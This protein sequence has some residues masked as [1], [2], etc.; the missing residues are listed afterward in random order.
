[1]KYLT[2]NTNIKYLYLLIMGAS[3]SVDEAQLKALQNTV[4]SQAGKINALDALKSKVDNLSTA[5]ASGI[6]YTKLAEAINKEANYREN[7]AKEIA[8]NPNELGANLA[9]EIGKNNSIIE[10]LNSK[11]GASTTLQDKVADTLSSNDKYK[12]RIRGPKGVDGN[13]GDQAALKSNLF[14]KGN[15]MWCADG[16]FCQIPDKKKGGDLGGIRLSDKWSGYPDAQR[17]GKW[18]SEISNDTDGFKKLMIVGNK[19]GG[20][21][22]RVGI[23]DELQVHGNLLV[24]GQT[25]KFHDTNFGRRDDWIRILQN[26]DDL[27]SYN[28]GIAAKNL[29][30]RDKL[31]V[32]GRDILAEIDDIKN[33]YVPKNTHIRIRSSKDDGYLQAADPWDARRSANRGSW[34][35][36]WIDND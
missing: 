8:K 4:N 2:N 32:A 28:V 18:T 6:E 25:I 7:L 20:G 26:P 34:E 31:W 22:R 23:W 36:W 1:M 13:I 12:E 15:T 35:R 9:A 10:N 29:W 16:E 19:S 21:A 14:E 3:S 17:N 27:N 5:A 33:R 11:L 24:D 30:A